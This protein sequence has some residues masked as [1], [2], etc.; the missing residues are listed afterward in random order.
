VN[1]CNIFNSENKSCVDTPTGEHFTVPCS[2]HIHPLPYPIFTC[3]LGIQTNVFTL[4]HFTDPY[5]SYLPRPGNMFKTRKVHDSINNP[6]YQ[7]L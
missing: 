4:V 7:Q 1:K 3:I 5:L 6:H 2:L